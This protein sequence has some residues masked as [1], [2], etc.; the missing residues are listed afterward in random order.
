MF[1]ATRKVFLD[2]FEPEEILGLATAPWLL[3]SL[4]LLNLKKT[5][6]AA[7]VN[8]YFSAGVVLCSTY[9]FSNT[10]PR[11]LTENLSRESEFS[12]MASR[13]R[14]SDLL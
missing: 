2:F 14:S 13:S 8:V 3:S 6:L 12:A 9:I 11:D 1:K 10:S 7:A 5:F 4:G